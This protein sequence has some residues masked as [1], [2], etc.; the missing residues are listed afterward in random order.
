M[1]ES[2][3]TPRG[4]DLGAGGARCAGAGGESGPTCSGEQLDVT[5]AS[6]A[7]TGSR[8]GTKHEH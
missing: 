5:W 8:T 7:W 2:T 4:V 1:G 3:P 6:K